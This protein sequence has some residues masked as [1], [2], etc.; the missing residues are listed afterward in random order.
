MERND[1]PEYSASIVIRNDQIEPGVHLLSLRKRF[2]FIS[3]QVVAIALDFMIEPRL[4]SIASGI[5][6]SE[7]R[8]L[9]D[10]KPEGRLSPR[11]GRLEPGDTVYVSNPTGTFTCDEKPAIWI[12]AGTGISPFISMFFSGLSE[13]KILIHGG[14]TKDSF[15]FAREILPVMDLRYI[16]YCSGKTVPGL[17]SGRLTDYLKARNGLDPELTYYLCGSAE[18]MLKLVKFS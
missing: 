11:L 9:F 18:M 4:Y 13:N 17:F 6:D 15:Y 7:L 16:R 8:I 1:S 14:R 3:G 2:S 5:N 10:I 12:A